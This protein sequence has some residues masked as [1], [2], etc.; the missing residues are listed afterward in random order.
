MAEPA[1]VFN[2]GDLYERT[3]GVWSRQAGQVFLDWLDPAPGQRWL[4]VGCGNGAFTE[5][6][7]QRLA[8][9][10]AQGIDPSAEQIAYARKRPG[11]QGA[12]FQQGDALALPFGADRFD[13]ATMALVLFFV[14]DPPKG[15]AEMARVV[16]PGGLVAAYAWDLLGGGFP[17]DAIQQEFRAQ[18][19]EPPLPPHPGVSREDAMARLWTEAGLQDVAT[20]AIRV[21]RTYPS[22]AEFWASTIQSASMVATMRRFS[23]DQAAAVKAGV[24]R[25]LPD[26]PDG[27]L[28]YGAVANAVMGRVPA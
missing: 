20:R 11:A 21:T 16:R 8:P 26:S 22:F 19:V 2:D 7:M 10:E 9:A 12:A 4:D 1:I 14:P 23:P 18:G 24:R 6:L 13:A 17:Y 28:T 15:V 3:M 27:T 5:L 25:R